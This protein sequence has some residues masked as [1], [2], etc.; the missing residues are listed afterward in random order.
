MGVPRPE[1][2]IE[3]AGACDGADDGGDRDLSAAQVD[4]AIAPERTQRLIE[5][6]YVEL[7]G[8]TT[9][10]QR[11]ELVHMGPTPCGVERCAHGRDNVRS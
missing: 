1:V 9:G 7:L 10:Q 5:R 3:V 2:A 6:Q 8:S 11:S 4:L